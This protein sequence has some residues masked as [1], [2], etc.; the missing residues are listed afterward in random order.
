MV[1]FPNCKINIGLHILGKRTDGYH[2]LETI[3]YPIAIND[4]VEIIES[5]ESTDEVNF[6]S[7]GFHIDGPQD[8][9]L[10]IKA[11]T[12]LR[13]QFPHLPPIKMHLHKA[14][15]M[16]AG[17]G[18]GSA[19]AAF[20]LQLINS[21]FSLQL[22]Q[23][24]LMGYALTLGSD[25]PFFLFNKACH[26]T[27]RGEILSPITLDLTGYS[28]IVINP[29][30]HISTALAFSSIKMEEKKSSLSEL[31]ANPISSWKDCISNDFEKTVFE[32]FPEIAQ[33]K[34]KLYLQGAI[35]ASMSGSGSSVYGIFNKG[36]TPIFN[37]PKRYFQKWV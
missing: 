32:A 36:N 25:C 5:D 33:I 19:D 22:T 21:K 11:Y 15:P 10:C 4:I 34:N 9:N 16:G 12:L 24:Q 13:A 17:L 2:N 27:G 1:S 35:Y 6:S 7:S 20:T 23:E 37:F 14:I 18:G 30:I 8:Q 3:F 29:G 28:I 26:G 31:I